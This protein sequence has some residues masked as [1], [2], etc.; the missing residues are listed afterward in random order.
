MFTLGKADIHSMKNQKYFFREH[1][2]INKKT[3]LYNF[4]SELKV[5]NICKQ[6]LNC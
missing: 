3:V 4:L 6:L 1:I 2:F 5:F